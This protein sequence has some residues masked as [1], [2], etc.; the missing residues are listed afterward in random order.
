[1]YH[2]GTQKGANEHLE[3]KLRCLNMNVI[4]M[5]QF[6]KNECPNCIFNYHTLDFTCSCP[7]GQVLD[8]T[9]KNC[10]LED[11]EPENE[12]KEENEEKVGMIKPNT[13]PQSQ[14][15]QPHTELPIP[16]PHPKE[17][18]PLPEPHPKEEM[19]LP[20]PQ[21][22][23][24]MP[25]MEPHPSTDMA[26]PEPHPS[27]DVPAPEPHP[28]TDVP[29][30]EPHPSTDVPAPE[31]HP[32]TDVP[33]PEPHPST[34][35]PAPEPHPSTDVPAP[36]PHPSTDVPAPEPHPSTDVPAPEPHPSTDV[37]APEPHPSTDVPAPEPHPSTDVPAPEPHPS[38]D[39]P[40]PEPHPSTDVPAPEP[41]PSTD[42][43][44]PE[45]QPSTDVP[46]P[47]P[48]PSTDVPAP[49]PQ[50]S[51]DVPA[52]EPQPSTDVPAPEPQP[53]T[54][55]P[56][57]EPQPSTD[58][59]APEPHPSTDVPAP[60]PHPSTD[61]P[62]PEPHPSTDVPAPEPHPSTDVPAPE[63]HPSTDVPAPE[64]H[65]STDVPA[66][67]PHP[68]TDVPA[69]EPH[70]ST[71]VP[72]PEPQPS[73]DVP[74]PEPQPSTESS[75]PKPLSNTEFPENEPGPS[76]DSSHIEVL[77][78][79]ELIQMGLQPVL[80]LEHM[81]NTSLES[82]LLSSTEITNEVAIGRE[83]GQYHASVTEYQPGLPVT[84][85]SV[86]SETNN[87]LHSIFHGEVDT[88]KTL[89]SNWNSSTNDSDI[90][91]SENKEKQEITTKT[92]NEYDENSLQST[93]YHDLQNA[94][95]NTSEISAPEISAT[96]LISPVNFENNTETHP[97]ENELDIEYRMN[98][99]HQNNISDYLSHS[100]EMPNLEEQGM[101]TNMMRIQEM[102]DTTEE[103]PIT[104]ETLHS[105]QNASEDA[106][107]G[108]EH[109]MF[110]FDMPFNMTNE[111]EGR[112][113][114]SRME[115]DGEENIP[116]KSKQSDVNATLYNKPSDIRT[117]NITGV[118][119]IDEENKQFENNIDEYG[120]NETYYSHEMNVETVLD[121]S[122]SLAHNRSN[123]NNFDSES[124]NN[125][126]L[127]GSSAVENN[128][129]AADKNADDLI[130]SENNATLHSGEEDLLER[131]PHDEK[132]PMSQLMHTLVHGGYDSGETLN[133][134][135]GNETSTEFDGKFRTIVEEPGFVL[136]NLTTENDVTESVSI[137]NNSHE[138]NEVLTEFPTHELDGMNG[139]TETMLQNNLTHNI[140]PPE[141][142]ENHIKN[143]LASE[144]DEHYLS[145]LKHNHNSSVS[146]KSDLK[147]HSRLD[148]EMSMVNPRENGTH[149]IDV[150]E[151]V[152]LT[153]PAITT[154]HSN[155]VGEDI[156]LKN[157][158]VEVK[159]F[160]VTET[161]LKDETGPSNDILSDQ[162]NTEQSH[163][164]RVNSE[165][166]D[167][168]NPNAGNNAS[169]VQ[170][171]GSAIAGVNVSSVE[172]DIDD[173]WNNNSN[174][175]RQNSSHVLKNTESQNHMHDDSSLNTEQH[176]IN[177][178]LNASIP[179]TN[180]TS[181][182][183]MVYENNLVPLNQ[184]S[185]VDQGLDK[186]LGV[187]PLEKTLE[188]DS[189]LKSEG[190]I[191]ST[192]NNETVQSVAENAREPTE[193]PKI[194]INSEPDSTSNETI[195]KASQNA[196]NLTNSDFAGDS[197][198]TFSAKNES[199]AVTSGIGPESINVVSQPGVSSIGSD[200]SYIIG[201]SKAKTE[202]E[203]EG[204]ENVTSTG[205]NGENLHTLLSEDLGNKLVN[206]V[207]T[208]NESPSVKDNFGEVLRIPPSSDGNT[209]PP[210]SHDVSQVGVGSIMKDMAAVNAS[211]NSQ[212]S[213]IDD[214]VLVDNAHSEILLDKTEVKKK[215]L[216]S[217]GN[218]KKTNKA[219]DLSYQE[220]EDTSSGKLT[221]GIFDKK[222][223]YDKDASRK[224]DKIDL[225]DAKEER[226]NV[227]NMAFDS[228]NVTATITDAPKI[229]EEQRAVDV[230]DENENALHVITDNSE[231]IN[232]VHES[233]VSENKREKK[234]SE[235]MGTKEVAPDKIQRQSIV[236]ATNSSTVDVPR[237]SVM[238]EKDISMAEQEKL[239]LGA[240]VL[241]SEQ[242]FNYSMDDASIPATTSAKENVIYNQP[243]ANGSPELLPTNGELPRHMDAQTLKVEEEN[244]VQDSTNMTGGESST[245]INLLTEHHT[246][247]LL[248]DL[249]D[250]DGVT[251]MDDPV[252]KTVS[253]MPTITANDFTKLLADVGIM[254]M[255]NGST[256]DAASVTFSK[257]AAGQFQCTNGT[258]R[259]GAYCVSFS[260]KCD[261]VNDCS[262]GSDEVGCMDEGCPGNFQCASGQC[263]KRHLVCNGII[264][265]DDSSD[266]V[267]CDKWKCLFDEFQCPS[268]RCIPVLW[269][270]DGKPDCA[271]HTD[272]YNCQSTCG[273]DEFL[274]SELW[275]IPMTWRCNGQ[276]ECANGE[277]EK[278]CDC[279][280]DQ[281]KCHTGGCIRRS[282][283]CD[284]VEHCPD[285]SDEWDCLKI[286]KDTN[287]LQIRS[288][289]GSWHSVCG[290][291]WDGNVSDLVCRELGY[292]K[293]VSTDLSP[294]PQ[295]NDT[296]V[297]YGLKQGSE[298]LPLS[299]QQSPLT[300]TSAS[301]ECTSGST[302]EIS[303]QEFCEAPSNTYQRLQLHCSPQINPP[304]LPA[305]EDTQGATAALRMSHCIG[306]WQPTERI[307]ALVYAHLQ[308]WVQRLSSCIKDTGHFLE[309]LR[310][311]SPISQ[312][313]SLYTNIP[314]S[315]R[316][317][318]IVKSTVMGTRMAPL[319]ANLFMGWLEENFLSCQPTQPRYWM[320][321]L[322]IFMIR[323]YTEDSLIH[324]LNSLN[325]HS[326]LK[327][328]W[329]YSKTHA[330]FLEVEL[331]LH[332]GTI[333]TAV[334][335]KP[336]NNLQYSHLG[337]YHSY[338]PENPYP[339]V[340][341]QEPNISA[342]PKVISTNN[343]Q[344][345]RELLN[346][347]YLRHLVHK[348]IPQAILNTGTQTKVN[349]SD[350]PL[351]VPYHEALRKFAHILYSGYKIPT[352]SPQ[353][354]DLLSK[355]PRLVFK[356]LPTFYKKLVHPKLHP[357]PKDPTLAITCGSCTTL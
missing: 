255:M 62:A 22:S 137:T 341:P 24:D 292:S 180:I 274:C 310:H 56:A 65:P 117:D 170:N 338:Q 37:P 155:T 251:K 83:I 100:S 87:V 253:T 74:A 39:V 203:A 164:E 283:V 248:K 77:S 357:T 264:D 125:F 50:P 216:S 287:S 209:I 339:T 230:Q 285:S 58:V 120:I 331:T 145:E 197:W 67:E 102:T 16:E 187:I 234:K 179:Q 182:N 291:R 71:D 118:L 144:E 259:E 130:S 312:D 185:E 355:P 279:T 201:T 64:P 202:I 63:P 135:N 21:P 106:T 270:C 1:M 316:L 235:K 114:L 204:S 127:A 205:E 336:T 303:C 250:P 173:I 257:C 158:S 113:K 76:S 311:L 12:I 247:P 53:S 78:N 84:S 17:E 305:S 241:S 175:T 217:T 9:G 174:G 325:A 260:A 88:E 172:N 75:L 32:S 268:G 146:K 200:T 6:N 327:F 345:A 159:T 66:P 275:C 328:I 131:K 249:G 351:V 140:A 282:Q 20:E 49:E 350:I 213:P 337:S 302:V 2:L 133:D 33:A 110:H 189:I 104:T 227:S 349:N 68:S 307:S 94:E 30:P 138:V 124:Q 265:C 161:I 186:P 190:E 290:D 108:G 263:L 142:S 99:T 324:F 23:T 134:T 25:I 85:H 40:A 42:V 276:P 47:E 326:V 15:P 206:H 323:T 98:L 221:N 198:S 82:E 271:N 81:H 44:A 70:P 143:S 284:G 309:C 60:E 294:Q 289:E 225:L 212:E 288:P 112:Q 123:D 166:S 107:H 18:M 343:E 346:T 332:K 211:T 10:T 286:Q 169:K 277:D 321:F 8:V 267:D 128:T 151:M 59:P 237:E 224:V 356:R 54:D 122:D 333:Q 242:G 31:P 219:T 89:H 322:D 93:R 165:I 95:L 111:V 207:E 72:A 348:Q 281:F 199:S 256:Q 139:S 308:H 136:V 347:G 121:S 11:Y 220:D 150:D 229:P 340:S 86:E 278:L 318:A 171:T 329:S 5:C 149:G 293:A 55:V 334:H 80:S 222:G 3:M 160:N 96:T 297:Y 177:T 313:A 272:E 239:G 194:K 152:S 167:I 27:T 52:P 191:L 232:T 193:T 35:V 19:P 269:Q 295:G 91:N 141:D 7:P 243:S 73:T 156:I 184:P 168:N 69:P 335:T 246:E 13:E 61:V 147:K 354:Q 223:K 254:Q 162:S 38:T 240:S 258:S 317:S 154:D 48:H 41:H 132:D 231:D 183:E 14:E 126:K 176:Q 266:E 195:D 261:S 228:M 101:T 92:S 178:Q 314:H 319:Y 157:A 79:T 196:D 238:S 298:T 43:P 192:E 103:L 116:N 299:R 301:S 46:A 28:S 300:L 344:I 34:D 90:I 210:T 306:Y 296:A 352:S 105:V 320:H 214:R 109:D 252:V 36:E 4:D 45:P 148:D 163:D 153:D 115:S 245:S 188:N 262:D 181:S 226:V 119:P 215:D 280:V 208:N 26:I 129:A 51:T 330:I 29:P 233:D 244:I 304:H 218:N 315:S 342:P 97:N 353:T 57:P 236:D 273:N